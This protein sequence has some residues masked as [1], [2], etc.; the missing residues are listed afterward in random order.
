VPKHELRI[1]LGEKGQ[2]G[3]ATVSRPVAGSSSDA[4]RP[5][6]KLSQQKKTG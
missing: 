1:D 6:K 3:P 2:V 4:R 5:V